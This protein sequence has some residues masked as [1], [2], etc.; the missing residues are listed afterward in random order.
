LLNFENK[1]NTEKISLEDFVSFF[2]PK[3]AINFEKL[4]NYTI[5][6]FVKP[7]EGVEVEYDY[8]IKNAKYVVENYDDIVNLI[9]K[10]LP[11]FKFNE[12]NSIDQAI[13][14]L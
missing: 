1:K 3:N 12:L 7:K 8:L 14:L 6:F 4:V 2:E 9:N 13:L 11:T 10:N 5:K